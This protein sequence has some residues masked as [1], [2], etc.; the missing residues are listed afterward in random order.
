MKYNSLLKNSIFSIFYKLLNVLFPLISMSYV[1]R[2][3]MASGVGKVSAA[4]NIVTYFVWIAA[5]GLPFYGTRE[6]AKHRNEDDR[7]KVFTELFAINFIST[8]ICV[9]FY[10]AIINFFDIFDGNVLLRNLAGLTLVFNYINVDWFYQG[11]EEYQYIAI[12]SFVVKIISLILIFLFVKTKN[13]YFIYT[14]IYTLAIAGN[15]FLNIYNLRRYGVSIELHNLN[16]LVHLKPLLVLLSAN[17]AIEI[18]TLLDTTML[19]FLCTDS[20]VGYY[21]NTIKLIKVVTSIITAIASILLPRFSSLYREGKYEEINIIT[22]FVFKIMLIFSIAAGVG[23]FIL[24]PYIIPTFFGES[25]IPAIPIARILSIMIFVQAFSTLLGTQI[26]IMAGDEKKM[27]FSTLVPAIVNVC[28]NML[29]IPMFNA[30]GAAFASVVS[31]VIC[32]VMTFLFARKYV[33]IKISLQF[34]LSNIVATFCMIIVVLFIIYVCENTL[35]ILL[36]SCTTGAIVYMAILYLMKNDVIMEIKDKYLYK[37]IGGSA[38]EE[39]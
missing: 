38:H 2:V 28:M 24:S 39:V 10:Y 37:K 36:L 11:Y 6:I 29:L 25:F 34:I 33:K 9:C 5:L 35:I 15:N 30:E 20:V 7:N 8:T 31:E 12:R 32:T 13:D 22:N 4:Q 1:S 16:M 21:S 14:F 19:S 17:I 23:M 26:L 3:L 27:F 18:Y